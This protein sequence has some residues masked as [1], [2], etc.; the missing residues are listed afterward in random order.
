MVSRGHCHDSSPAGLVVMTGI[1]QGT[2][3]MIA[4]KKFNAY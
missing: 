3:R 2:V 4:A 1:S